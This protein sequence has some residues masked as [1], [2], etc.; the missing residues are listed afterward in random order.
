MDVPIEGS[1]V[2]RPGFEVP[3]ELVELQRLISLS[4]ACVELVSY[5]LYL[6]DVC[7]MK[8]PRRDLGALALG[9]FD[10]SRLAL[11]WKSLPRANPAQLRYRGLTAR[12]T[13]RTLVI[14]IPTLPN[15]W[16]SSGDFADVPTI[17]QPAG[18]ESGSVWSW[19]T[20]LM[21]IW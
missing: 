20:Q 6:F 10:L 15:A 5:R 18:C 12:E 4:A 7:A 19:C 3:S 9:V 14:G 1:M 21:K 8:T 16:R 11:A 2:Q 17:V 13:V